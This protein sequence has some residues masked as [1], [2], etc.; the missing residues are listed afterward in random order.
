[1]T[2]PGRRSCPVRAVMCRISRDGGPGTQPATLYH[3]VTKPNIGVAHAAIFI[4]QERLDARPEIDDAVI[5]AV[6]AVRLFLDHQ[7]STRL[8]DLT[9]IEVVCARR[10]PWIVFELVRSLQVDAAAEHF[11]VAAI[12]THC[13]GVNQIVVRGMELPDRPLESR[14]IQWPC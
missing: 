8:V 4:Q 3:H 9:L 7:P 5:V 13:E 12:D 1:M 11:V 10:D 6:A 14:T 2:D